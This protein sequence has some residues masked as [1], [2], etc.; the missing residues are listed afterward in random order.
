MKLSKKLLSKYRCREDICKRAN[1]PIL[2]E[3]SSFQHCI[4][5]NENFSIPILSGQTVN[6]CHFN[7][8]IINEKHNLNC[9]KYICCEYV[10]PSFKLVDDELHQLGKDFYLL[11]KNL[12]KFHTVQEKFLFIQQNFN[13]IINV[14]LLHNILNN[15]CQLNNNYSQLFTSE[16][17]RNINISL[18]NFEY[19][20]NTVIKNQI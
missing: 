11:L 17:E 18:L 4:F 15:E 20:L 7:I 3:Y 2:S 5:V 19:M 8:P 1:I 9:Y 14:L 16:E 6:E 10:V 13:K 12:K